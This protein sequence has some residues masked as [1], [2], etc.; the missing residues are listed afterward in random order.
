M[1]LLCELAKIRGYDHGERHI[2]VVRVAYLVGHVVLLVRDVKSQL[3]FVAWH[4][5]TDLDEAY[6][7][8]W[9]RNLQRDYLVVGRQVHQEHN[10]NWRGLGRRY[11]SDKVTQYQELD[12]DLSLM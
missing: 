7:P 3:G 5:T 2:L 4:G 10:A 1:R 12:D 8:A 6:E 11:D 9:L